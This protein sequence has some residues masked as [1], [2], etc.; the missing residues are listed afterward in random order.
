M[1]RLY[2]DFEMKSS[3]V[4][5]RVGR[6]VLSGCSLG[7]SLVSGSV[8]ASAGSTDY[9]CDWIDAGNLTLG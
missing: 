8:L 2:S 6:G 4:V 7:V 3:G 1:S 5:I 9:S